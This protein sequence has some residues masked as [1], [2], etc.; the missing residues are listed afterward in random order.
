MAKASVTIIC[1]ECGREFEHT[2]TCY[3]RADAEHY[4]EWAADNIT[5]C[6]ECYSKQKRA[7]ERAKLDNATQMAYQA[8]AGSGI[9]LSGLTGTSKQIKWANDIRA[10]AAKMVIDAK[11]RETVWG[12]F[13]SKTEAKWWIE[14]RNECNPELTNARRLYK[15]M[16]EH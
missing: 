2:H 6:P 4:E 15:Y 14:N 16:L 3:N 5:V 1:E 12:V 9:V 13:N 7:D 11:P 10:K 8:I